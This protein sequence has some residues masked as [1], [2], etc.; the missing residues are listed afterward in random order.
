MQSSSRFYAPW[1]RIYVFT[2]NV[3]NLHV[4]G[5]LET[6]QDF[7]IKLGI[8]PSMHLLEINIFSLNNDLVRLT[9]ITNKFDKD[10]KIFKFIF[11]CLKLV[12]SNLSKKQSVKNIWL[13]YQIFEVHTLFTKKVP[14]FFVGSVHNFGNSGD[15]II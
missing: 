5:L 13:G 3:P 2:L 15:D 12:E 11:Q 8:K 9:K 4:R 7:L 1:T 6:I 10:L 14:N